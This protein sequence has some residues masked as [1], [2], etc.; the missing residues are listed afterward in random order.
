MALS[1]QANY[2]DWASSIPYLSLKLF[3]VYL[4]DLRFISN[5]KWVFTRWWYHYNNTPHKFVYHIHTKY[6]YHTK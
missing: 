6:T 4:Y 1:P 3:K 5:F 2:T